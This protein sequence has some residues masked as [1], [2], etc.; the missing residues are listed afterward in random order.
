MFPGYWVCATIFTRSNRPILAQ[1]G[2]IQNF[3]FAKYGHVKHYFMPNLMLF[4]EK[5]LLK[6]QIIHTL[7][8]FF[9]KRGI[10]QFFCN[11]LSV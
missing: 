2:K 3:T 8:Y 10:I 1:V 7:C 6:S 5:P 11:E 9:C 4:Q